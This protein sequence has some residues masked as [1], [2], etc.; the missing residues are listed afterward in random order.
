MNSPEFRRHPRVI[1]SAA[2]RTLR[3]TASVPDVFALRVVEHFDVV[4]HV[5]ASFIA[6]TVDPST[7]SLSLQKIEKALGHRIV[8]AVAASAHRVNQIVVLE[9]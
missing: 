7:Y 3:A 5:L 1:F 8:M 2:F 9:E 4:E 6:R